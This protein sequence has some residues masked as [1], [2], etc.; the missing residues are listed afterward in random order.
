MSNYGH[1]W[2]LAQQCAGDPEC[3]RTAVIREGENRLVCWEHVAE[4]TM[5]TVRPS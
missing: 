3:K 1:A 5:G 2:L 4:E